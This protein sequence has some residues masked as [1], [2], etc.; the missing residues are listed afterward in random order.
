MYVKKRYPDLIKKDLD[1]HVMYNKIY[2]SY[3]NPEGSRDQIYDVCY[4]NIYD[5][6][7]V[8]AL[9]SVTN[10]LFE[11]LEEANVTYMPV[12]ECLMSG[13]IKKV[14]SPV[15]RIAQEHGYLIKYRCP[16]DEDSF[17]LFL[18]I[19]A[20]YMGQFIGL[21]SPDIIRGIVWSY[22]GGIDD[23]IDKSPTFK[24]Y[25]VQLYTQR[26]KDEYEAFINSAKNNNGFFDVLLRYDM[27][28][29]RYIFKYLVSCIDA[30]K[31]TSFKT[32]IM[33]KAKIR[34]GFVQFFGSG[35]YEYVTCIDAN[36]QYPSTIQSFNLSFDT[37]VLDS[38]FD[39]IPGVKYINIDWEQKDGHKS[40]SRFVR[41]ESHRGILPMVED[42][43]LASRRAVKAKLKAY[44]SRK[45]D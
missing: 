45:K 15:S 24:Q 8:F 6:V 25:Y 41:S 21:V 5:C 34:G 43:L 28:H 7:S 17:I 10:I 16:T 12:S 29:S 14:L 9:A 39:N 31:Y 22:D 27:S 33:K 30:A 23:W 18:R 2:D 3:H 36:S 20:E 13:M 26:E 44:D 42:H 1:Y 32:K 19:N 4:Y 11:V 35:L 38:R 40:R 37:L